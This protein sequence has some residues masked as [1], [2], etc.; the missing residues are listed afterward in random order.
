MSLMRFS[1]V[2]ERG[3][4]RGRELGFPTANLKIDSA[5]LELS[6]GVYLGLVMWEGPPAFNALINFGLRPTFGEK[7]MSLEL[8]IM[9]FSGDLYG[10][11]LDVNIK[12][13]LRDEQ[14]FDGRKEL[15]QQI[16]ADIK[17]ARMF[18]GN[19]SDHFK[20]KMED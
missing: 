12:T 4:G 5:A 10:K 14:R 18:L 15:I 19:T 16:Q 11:T 13:R 6:R 2:V 3:Q 20:E 17:Q 9:D 8:H 1:G 7:E